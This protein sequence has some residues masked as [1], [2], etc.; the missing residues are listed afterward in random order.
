MAVFIV[1]VLP[2]SVFRDRYP[3]AFLNFVDMLA[4]GRKCACIVCSQ[5]INANR[6]LASMVIVEPLNDNTEIIAFPVCQDCQDK[7]D[8]AIE[9]VKKRLE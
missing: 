2:F 1:T 8:A 9:T 6:R 5:E 7:P 4:A 3:P